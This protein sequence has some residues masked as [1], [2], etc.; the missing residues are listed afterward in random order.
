MKINPDLVARLIGRKVKVAR[1]EKGLT[2]QQLADSVDVSVRRLGDIERGTAKNLQ[3]NTIVSLANAL[4]IS[5]SLFSGMG[6]TVEKK[7]YAA[8][9]AF[10]AVARQLG[11]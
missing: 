9:E 6:S 1:L 8:E 4:D 10:Q 2:Q 5:D 3:L 7:T 11:R